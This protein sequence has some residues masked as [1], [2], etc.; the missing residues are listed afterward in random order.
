VEL[1]ISVAYG[2]DITKIKSLLSD[3]VTNREDIMH[4]PKPSVFV[5]NISEVSVDFKVSFWASE[6]AQWV[7]LKSN[8]LSE[9]YTKFYE[10]GIKLPSRQQDLT[11]KLPDGKT[12]ELD[13]KVKPV[14]EKNVDTTNSPTKS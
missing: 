8:V 10:E 5:H 1:V 3:L 2:S 6:I 4:Y 12:I 14:D 7:E 9:I 11:L 13:D